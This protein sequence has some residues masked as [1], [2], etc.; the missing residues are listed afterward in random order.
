M[1]NVTIVSG[2]WDIGRED[3]NFEEIYLPRFEKFL[4]TDLPMIL[5]LP[6]ELHEMVW[7]VRDQ[8]NTFVKHFELEDFKTNLF[9]PHWDKVQGIRTS[10]EWQNIT[11]KHGWLHKAP[12]KSYEWYN[13]VVMSKMFMLNDA[14]IYNNFNTEFFFWVDAGLNMTVHEAALND[15]NVYK[16]AAEVGN[17]FLFL[18]FPYK[19][20][21]EVH[22]FNEDILQNYT[23]C[24]TEY[25]CRGGFFGGHREGI[26][27][28]NSIYYSL[29][30]KS[31]R[32]GAMGTE[33]TLFTIMAYNEPQTFRRYML[34]KDG[35]I[36]KFYED[37]LKEDFE[38]I[39]VDLTQAQERRIITNQQIDELITNLYILTFNFPDQIKHT[40]E[41][42]KKT[43]IWLEKPNI[44]LLD[45]S[46]DDGAIEENKR[47]CT[48]HGFEYIGL[49][50]NTG[51][52]GGRQAAAEHFHESNAHYMFFFEDDMTLNPPELQGQVCRNGFSKYVENV[53]NLVHKIMEIEDYDFLKLS[54]TE[55]YMDNNKQCSWYNVP[56]DIRERDW[57][58][59]NKLPVQGLDP[60]SPNTL[61]KYIKNLE[62]TS[63][64]EGEIYYANWPMIVSKEGNKK[65]FIDQ[66]WE[67]EYEQTWM[68]HIY[69]LQ[70]NNRINAAVLLASPIWHD[71]IKHYKPEERKENNG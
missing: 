63:Y 48:E 45:N 26:E 10:E 20:A 1:S 71:R 56:Q 15:V 6:K 61:F 34:R 39:P 5:F 3:R 22:G 70:K 8:S 59:Q 19:P 14:R 50:G 12:Q 68:S 28:A 33:E 11:G 9:A 47:L 16:R 41:T 17:P 38:L 29:L 62:G 35:H 2:L 32:Q 43:P 42:M 36:V 52:C 67:Y 7:K 40:L 25:V 18:S 13:P 53:Y 44:I 27:R 21:G 23:G 49:G 57:P 58:D 54:F 66:K 60:D 4:Q 31:L 64:I 30:D 69:Q 55:V 46:T 24:K 37:V 65:M 51:I